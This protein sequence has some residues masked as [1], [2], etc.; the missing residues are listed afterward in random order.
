MTQNKEKHIN[1][2]DIMSMIPHRHP[3]LLV[4]K[5][6]SIETNHSIVGI[7]NVTFNEP[8]FAGHFPNNP[9]MPGVLII[10]AL[11]QISAVLV[12]HS[13]GAKKEEKLVY[14]MSI[15]NAKFRKIVRPGDSLI[16]KSLITQHRSD[17]WKFLATAEVDGSV[18]AESNFMA[19]IKNKEQVSD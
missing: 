4:D 1:I 14:F 7:K 19:M 8:Q 16:L 9:V 5:V 11:A 3:F 10:E 6:I 12:A 13:I 17:V 2:V 15:D 18:V